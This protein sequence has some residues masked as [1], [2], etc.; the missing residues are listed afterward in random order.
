MYQFW[1]YYPTVSALFQT[2]KQ[3]GP[4][5][6][7]ADNGLL[8]TFWHSTGVLVSCSYNHFSFLFRQISQLN[9]CGFHPWPVSRY[10]I[11]LALCTWS[12]AT[13]IEFILTFYYL[14]NSDLLSIVK[15]S[16]T[17]HA[18]STFA[19]FILLNILFYLYFY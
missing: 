12:L 3:D 10:Y 2:I 11:F 1:V 9:L 7:W 19:W 18:L 5:F 6:F 15:V 13:D 14:K 4:I 17:K 16:L 8:N